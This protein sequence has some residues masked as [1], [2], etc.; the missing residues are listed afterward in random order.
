MTMFAFLSWIVIGVVIGA[1]LATIWKTRG[2]TLA[3][4]TA[5]GGVGGV[6][7]GMLARYVLPDGAL[8]DGLALAFAVLGAVVAMFLARTRVEHKDQPGSVV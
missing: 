6:A 8:Y 3:W 5:V 2:L 4:G 7:A 1:V